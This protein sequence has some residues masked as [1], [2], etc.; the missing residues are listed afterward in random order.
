M[1]P[2]LL[3]LNRLQHRSQVLRKITDNLLKGVIQSVLISKLFAKG[4]TLLLNPRGYSVT[5]MI[6][7]LKQIW[8]SSVYSR[9]NKRILMSRAGNIVSLVSSTWDVGCHLI[10]EKKNPLIRIYSW[11]K[12]KACYIDGHFATSFSKSKFTRPFNSRW[13]H[14]E[15]EAFHRISDT[16]Q[17]H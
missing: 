1:V 15:P 11:S 3:P 16:L 10:I 5:T 13:N 7:V 2:L 8:S 12:I 9:T 6:S 4:R 17:S 14:R